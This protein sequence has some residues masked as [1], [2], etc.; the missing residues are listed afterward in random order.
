MNKFNALI[1]K[2]SNSSLI[3]IADALGKLAV[4]A[5]ILTWILEIDDR[6][7][8][9][10]NARQDKLYRAFEIL[11]NQTFLQVG[12]EI[13]SMA[14]QDIIHEGVS[15][16]AMQFT[17]GLY[18]SID[19]TGVNLQDAWIDETAFLNVKFV[20]SNLSNSVLEDMI[21]DGSDFTGASFDGAILKDVDFSEAIGLSPPQFKGAAI[22]PD[23]KFPAQFKLDDVD[24]SGAGVARHYAKYTNDYWET[25]M[26]ECVKFE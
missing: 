22:C 19:L 2:I 25:I 7:I 16:E 14:L 26:N 18:R 5:V 9:R 15:L 3:K 10:E 13:P 4:F 1:D 20:N 23:V 12:G 21:F 17:G 11:A 6:Q 8:A 24:T